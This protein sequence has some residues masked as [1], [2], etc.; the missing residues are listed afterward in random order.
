MS[1]DKGIE[2]EEAIFKKMEEG[3]ELTD[4]EVERLE[5]LKFAGFK[6]FEMSVE[7]LRTARETFDQIVKEGRSK[8]RSEMLA[9]KMV[10][11]EMRKVILSHLDP[12]SKAVL[13]KDIISQDEIWKNIE[14]KKPQKIKVKNAQNF[15]DL[16]KMSSL[17][18]LMD[19]MDVVDR[20]S[21][22][23]R[24]FLAR[25]I[26]DPWHATDNAFHTGFN[27]EI[28]ILEKKGKEIFGEDEFASTLEENSEEKLLKYE[29]EFSKNKKS[30]SLSQNQAAYLWHKCKILN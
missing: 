16:V 5:L 9:Q 11:E 18:S 2:E 10:D 3:G 22:P 26:A 19:K 13:D 25:F 24:G 4:A 8:S 28:T 15:L 14:G 23:M 1:R 12:L 29:D 27:E 7:D 20:D 6:N 21:S 30:L 17:W